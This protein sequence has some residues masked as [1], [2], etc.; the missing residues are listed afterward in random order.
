MLCGFTPDARGS[1]ILTARCT[2]PG[3]HQALDRRIIP[4]EKRGQ[5]ALRNAGHGA[6]DIY[7]FI[8][9]SLLPLIL[10][11]FNMKYGTAGGILTA[12]LIVVAL[13]S[14]FFGKLSDRISRSILMGVGFLCASAFIIFAS[15]TG[16]LAA[17][18]VLIL[19]AG[20][21][22]S[23]FHP[24]VYALIG[25]STTHRRGT[26]YGMF[27]FWGSAA[28]FLMFFLHG[29]LLRNLSWRTVIQI[30][31]VPGIVAGIL[32]L[33]TSKSGAAADRYPGPG[34]YPERTE[35]QSSDPP[36]MPRP[37][38]VLFL[39]VVALRFFGIIAVVNFSPTYLVRE[40]GLEQSIASFA[41]GLYFLGGLIF[42]PIVGGL[43]D[44]RD[45]FVVLLLSTA[46][47]FPLILLVSSPFPVWALP[48]SILLLGG[49]YYG[50][51]PAMDIII[52]RMSSTMGR[53]E[54]FGY[55]MAIISVTYSFSPLLYGVVADRLGLQSAMRLFSFPVLLSAAA[56]F[57]LGRLLK[58]ASTVS[59][60]RLRFF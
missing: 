25:E 11:Q 59:L 32:F 4:M 17:F 43:C 3:G 8:L 60:S 12:F 49:M 2:I 15:F 53:G 14:Y 6:N 45:P 36:G 1:I 41:T 58:D 16:G 5:A 13:F 51:G 18:V 39:L 57:V 44:R 54:A 40:V 27:E 33:A 35:E 10:E 42:T 20:I 48:F 38:F 46:A 22:V 55:F 29:L 7:W 47:A 26:A 31:S 37:L 56:L 23:T 30:S 24:P 21:G 9:P 50:A 52:S 34:A 19:I 28:V